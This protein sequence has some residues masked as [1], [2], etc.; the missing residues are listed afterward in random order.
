MLINRL[1][2]MSSSCA[3]DAK[4]KVQRF[5]I[6]VAFRGFQFAHHMRQR[7]PVHWHVLLPGAAQTTSAVVVCASVFDLIWSVL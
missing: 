7:F 5:V 4:S 6:I 2:N 3:S 1:R